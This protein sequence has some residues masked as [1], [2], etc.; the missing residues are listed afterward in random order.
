[1]PPSKMFVIGSLLYLSSVNALSTNFCPEVVQQAI[2]QNRT[3]GYE[4]HCQCGKALKNLI[5]SVPDGFS[6]A[7]ICNFRTSNGNKLDLQKGPQ[8]LDQFRHDGSGYWGDVFFSG[9]MVLRGTVQAGPADNG[10]DMWFNPKPAIVTPTLKTKSPAFA[11]YFGEGLKLSHDNFGKMFKSPYE[12]GSSQDCWRAKAKIIVEGLHVHMSEQDDNGIY[13][14]GI[15]L[16]E[17][18][19]FVRCK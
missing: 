10:G 11:S 5:V 1:M 7:G 19:K 2:Q 4:F 14:I 18:A 16:V 15:Q 3:L 6:V 8:S 13:P 17:V 9:K 12:G